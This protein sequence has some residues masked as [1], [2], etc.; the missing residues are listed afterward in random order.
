MDV[1]KMVNV[2]ELDPDPFIKILDTIGLP[3]EI[4]ILKPAAKH[5][6]ARRSKTAKTAAG[7]KQRPSASSHQWA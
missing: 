3:T 4:T 5:A 2:E 7:K 1:K 6:A